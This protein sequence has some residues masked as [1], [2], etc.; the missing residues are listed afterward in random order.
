MRELT[1]FVK[2]LGFGAGLALV[3]AIGSA[4]MAQAETIKVNIAYLRVETPPPV[5]LSNL[6]PRPEDLGLAGAALGAQDNATTGRF[7]GHE[8]QLA[9]ISLAPGSDVT[10]MVQD[11]PQT[12]D[13]IL[14]DMTSADLLTLAD[15]PV[16]QNALIFNVASQARDLRNDN[17]RANLLHT[18]TEVTMRS[19]ALMQMMLAK[20]WTKLAMIIG[21]TD[22]DRALADAYRA[23]ARKFG[24]KLVSEVNWTFDSDL[25][26]NASRE[27]PLLTQ[28]FKDHHAVLVADAA[29]DFARYIEHNTW[30]PRPVIGSTGLIPVAWDRVVEQWGAAQ[31][32]SR[33]GKLAG[34]SMQSRDY[35]AWAA[36]R[37]IGEAVTRTQSAQ[38]D[39]L[40]AYILSDKFELA[41]FQGRPLSFRDW[42]GQMR[43]PIPLVNARA[44]VGSAP[45]DG[46]EHA[47]NP[48]DSLGTD[49]PETTCT[50][51]GD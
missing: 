37:S 3:L 11:L 19:D 7:M 36:M 23:S 6:D 45:L 48:L 5:V 41:A 1:N 46:F 21:P 12:Y 26:R 35:A 44:V 18:A 30:T 22:A 27:V 24:L 50:A 13:L 2:N 51:F 31:L 9:T 34:R 33:F 47:R 42:N 29:D 43:Q 17:C 8:Y 4:S 16:M 15:L 25:R 14:A 28:G 39:V 40:R 10:A 38:A 20:R 32:Q 49:K